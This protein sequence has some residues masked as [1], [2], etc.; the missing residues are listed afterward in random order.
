MGGQE[1]GIQI[2]PDKILLKI[3]SYLPHK[4]GFKGYQQKLNVVFILWYQSSGSGKSLTDGQR[5][6]GE[7]WPLRFNI[8]VTL[9]VPS[10]RTTFPVCLELFYI[11][12]TKVFSM[13]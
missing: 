5:P 11:S 10:A 12:F 7:R 13:S 8:F 4:V 3:F 9:L 6:A 2:L 1:G